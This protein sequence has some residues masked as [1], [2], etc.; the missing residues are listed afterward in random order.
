MRKLLSATAL[1]L[2]IGLGTTATAG[3][4]APAQDSVTGTATH[5]ALATC[6]T[7]RVA[8]FRF[9]PNATSDP[10]GQAPGGTVTW[11]EKSLGDGTLG[12][13]TVTC[14]SVQGNT[15]IIGVTGTATFFGSFGQIPR[16]TAGLIRATDGGG[17]AS[18]L[19]TFEFHL[20]L[21]SSPS[22]PPLP[23]P[24]DCATFPAGSEAKHNV[25]GDLVVHDAPSRAARQ[26]ARQ[27][28]IFIRAAHGRP[29][30][31]AWYGEGAQKLRAMPR[32]VQ[33]RATD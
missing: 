29:A 32:C 10:S 30:F 2:S 12:D 21:R 4:Q 33:Q 26:Q 23:G 18:G 11:L 27:E 7:D 5:C 17:P 19:D 6:P 22:D 20:T 8:F 3:A 9:T 28:C 1:A 15:A 14:L 24:T 13:T 31:R 16:Y 25:E